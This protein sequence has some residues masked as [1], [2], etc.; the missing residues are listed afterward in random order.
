MIKA[1]L[2]D[3]DG[4]VLKKYKYFSEIF[5]E[6]YKVPLEKVTPFFKEKFALIQKGK[7]DLKQQIAPFLKTWGWQGT[8]DDF[9]RYW[10]KSDVAVNPAVLEVISGLRKKG[11]K[12][13][14]ATDQD[15][16]RAKYI[17]E[18]LKFNEI[19]DHAFY[20]CDLGFRKSESEFFTNVLSLLK[21]KPEEVIFWDDDQEN[22]KVAAALGINANRYS[23]LDELKD[24]TRQL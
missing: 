5:S 11:I 10:H 13:Y 17:Q 23:G 15:A 9:V 18:T 1:V 19:F 6:E 2:F 20:S 16:Y 12:C 14:L 24:K 3:A 21:L 8:V 22:V 7:A 4:V